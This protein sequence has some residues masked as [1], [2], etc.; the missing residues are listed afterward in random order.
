MTLAEK[1]ATIAGKL[2]Y[3]QKKGRNTAQSYNYVQEADVLEIVKP[4]LAEMKIITLPTFSVVENVTIQTAAG[5][6]AC[7]VTLQ[8][9]LTFKD[10]ET[11][12]ELQVMT[13]GQGVDSQDKAPYKAM[14]GANKYAFF[15]TFNIPSGDDPEEDAAAV[16]GAR[17]EDEKVPF[18]S[19]REEALEK[20]RTQFKRHGKDIGTAYLER[21]G[22]NKEKQSVSDFLAQATMSTINEV[23]EAMENDA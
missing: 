21:V 17:T 8:L 2:T 3:V 19:N 15:K 12:E 18:L 6:P 4:L 16:G 20:L 23:I 9:L 11:G 14:T 5:K 22:L 13:V 7:R 10:G 1:L